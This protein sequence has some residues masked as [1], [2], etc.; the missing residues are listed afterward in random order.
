MLKG[1]LKDRSYEYAI[2]TLYAGQNSV[3]STSDFTVASKFL[4]VSKMK[5][6]DGFSGVE[7]DV[8]IAGPVTDRDGEAFIASY[9]LDP[10]ECASLPVGSTYVSRIRRAPSL[11][12]D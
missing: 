2:S 8:Y 11:P 12:H 9:Q 10:P 1:Y 6:R 4:K 5:T 3:M 7:R